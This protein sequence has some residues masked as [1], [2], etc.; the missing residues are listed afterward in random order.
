MEVLHLERVLQLMELIPCLAD[1]FFPA[2]DGHAVFPSERG[3]HRLHLLRAEREE[4]KS[5]WK[6][7][8]EV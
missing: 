2:V 8:E 1:G 3:G 6:R 4:W 7:S 5:V